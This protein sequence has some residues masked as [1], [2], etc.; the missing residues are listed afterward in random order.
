MGIWIVIIIFGLC[1]VFSFYMTV[2]VCD[3]TKQKETLMK[4]IFGVIITLFLVLPASVFAETKG[5]IAEGEY[6]MGDGE[7]M[8]IAEERAQKDA[9][10][11][12]AEEAGAFIKSYTKVKNMALQEDVIEVI[13]N[14]SM[15]IT[16]LDKKRTMMGDAV[17]FYSKIKAVFT[18]EEI[19]ANLGKVQ[20]ESKTVDMYKR[21]L[22]EYSRQTKEMEELKKK[23]SVAQGED[24]KAIL[25][26][27]VA[28]ENLFKAN[29][30][31]E[32]GMKAMEYFIYEDAI[33]AFTGAI[34][35]NPMFADAFAVRS[36]AY[37][38]IFKFKKAIEDINKAI[39]IQPENPDL[40]VI[41][42]MT[43]PGCSD[44]YKNVCIKAAEEEGMVGDMKCKEI[45]PD[46]CK[47]ALND[48]GKTIQLRPENPYYYLARAKLYLQAEMDDKAKEDFTKV[49]S[50]SANLSEEWPLSLVMA[51][52]FRAQF[53]EKKKDYYSA[54]ADM[55]SAITIIENSKY[56]NE[57]LKKLSKIL[58]EAR[59]K[60][61]TDK[62]MEAAIKKEYKIDPRNEKEMGI[63][64]THG[65]NL[66][67]VSVL[68]MQRSD[69]YKDRGLKEKAD[70]DIKTACGL[71][72]IEEI[73]KVLENNAKK[74]T[75]KPS[76][77]K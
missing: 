10:R 49:I 39:E 59:I 25:G 48:I 52:L 29:L 9:V 7:T 5:I 34:A 16:V 67:F 53:V 33:E 36:D 13:A 74:S 19:E 71:Y 75:G 14:H 35:L 77:K 45:S 31:F 15:K 20:K 47:K 21:L 54:V 57:K 18:T 30:L 64:R 65:E 68:Y 73:C 69:I 1:A 62:Q 23:L 60:K 61:Y 44:S 66:L 51:Y 2:L 42:A 41:R 55:T 4:Y 12:A 22:D 50:M 6:I 11:H 56:Y 72:W 58:R 28:E 32:K 76:K 24:K 43:Y 38:A 3:E 63:L 17:K 26:K 37:S 40:Y 27:I 70:K 8:A 46:D